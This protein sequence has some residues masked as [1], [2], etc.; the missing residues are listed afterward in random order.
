MVVVWWVL[1]GCF[2]TPTNLQTTVYQ[3]ITVENIE[4]WWVLQ[5]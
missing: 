3:T 2:A 5:I 4:K 1:G